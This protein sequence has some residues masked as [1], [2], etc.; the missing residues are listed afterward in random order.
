MSPRKK[1]ERLLYLSSAP[2]K[3]AVYAYLEANGEKRSQFVAR[4]ARRFAMANR[5]AW[6][7]LAWVERRKQ[8]PMNVGDQMALA[9]GTHP[10]LIWGG[11]YENA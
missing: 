10:I 9:I 2:I 8:V 5:T 6:R 1:G 3:V 4:Y 7:D 11:E